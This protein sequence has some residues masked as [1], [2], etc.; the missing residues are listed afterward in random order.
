M[1]KI[2]KSNT[3]LIALVVT[4]VLLVAMALA[5]GITPKYIANAPEVATGIGARLACSMHFVMGHEEEQIAQDIKVY[6]PILS[7]LTYEYDEDNKTVS[8]Q[9]AGVKRSASW[10]PK[11]GCALNYEGVVRKQIDWPQ[12]Y[13]VT[14]SAPWPQGY[15]VRTTVPA[16]QSKLTSLLNKDN[17]LGFDTR[18]LLVVHKGQIVAESYAEGY[19]E[20][21]LFLGWS[22][23]KSVTGLLAGWVV[24]QGKMNVLEMGLF[25]EW[26]Q[27]ERRTI[28]IM[29][30][31]QMT[32]G[33][34]YD[35]TYKPGE[36]AP[37]MLFQT[38]DAAQYMI[39][40]PLR[41]TPGEYYSYSSGSTNLLMYLI[42]QRLAKDPSEAV[43]IIDNQFF[44]PLG[45]ESLVFE[46]DNQGLLMGSSY[47]YANARDWAKFGQLMLNGGHLNNFYVVTP[48]WVRESIQ[49]NASANKQNF[50][51]NWWLN[52]PQERWASLAPTAYS[53]KGNREQRIMVLPDNELVIVRL[54]WSKDDYRDDEIAAQ[55]MSWF[56]D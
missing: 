56:N 37:A 36:T 31:L 15:D 22:M 55:I 25:P 51:Y 38:A 16:L 23:A 9:I 10:Q 44:K 54:G 17:E 32:D 41:H 8:A 40:R 14:A 53:S 20:Q 11:M 13:R 26:M 19:N 12:H 39:D 30:L 21:S 4:P 2:K 49:P 6:S 33:L 46:S 27:D 24:Q 45:I 35:E 50:G 43:Q 7:F 5:A 42:Q 1:T 48:G 28:S 3:K 34:D 18:A 47:M 29:N 52:Q